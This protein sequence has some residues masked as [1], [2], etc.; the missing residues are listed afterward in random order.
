MKIWMSQKTKSNK[1]YAARTIL[2]IFGCIF[3]CIVLTFISIP[4]ADRLGWSMEAVSG[5]L[6]L[7]IT[8]LLV[9]LAVRIGLNSG[10]DSLIFCQ[11]ENHRL[12][13]INAAA[14]TSYRRGAIGF[15]A[16][17]SQ[18][19]K[20]LE[21]LK[22]SG[23]LERMMA[24]EQSLSKIAQEILWVET[25]KTNPNS[26]SVICQI[27][28]PNGN[29]RRG[30][31]ILLPGYD[32]EEELL[33]A[34][35]MKA[36]ARPQWEVKPNRN[37]LWIFISAFVLAADIILCVLSHMDVALLPGMLYYPCLIFALVPLYTL[38]YFMIKNVRGE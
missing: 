17:A 33:L 18:T 13:V 3:L 24:Q 36:A 38:L 15:A 21:Q 37:P 25:I 28:D 23:M 31:Y 11:D 30:T 35:Q 7:G 2:P 22:R 32:R 20:T 4:L 9:W 14:F 16:M 34:L 12:F 29:R 26:H 8:I 19:Q 27:Q 10:R 1:N 5:I 6:V